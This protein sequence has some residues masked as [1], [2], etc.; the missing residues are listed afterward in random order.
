[1]GQYGDWAKEQSKFLSVEPGESV[2]VEWTGK[3][4][5]ARGNYGEG[6]DFEF[7]VDESKKTMTIRNGKLVSKFDN[8]KAGDKLIIS[9]SVKDEAGKTKY[10][11]RKEGEEEAPF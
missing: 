8:Y 3:S 6:W 2:L 10:S 7:I 5:L 4:V 11:I 9:R 1:M